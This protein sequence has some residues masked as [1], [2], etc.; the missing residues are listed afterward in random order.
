MNFLL[1]IKTNDST[2]S[3]TETEK[4]ISLFLFHH[5]YFFD[6]VYICF[7]FTNICLFVYRI[8][9]IICLLFDLSILHISHFTN[10]CF[11]LFFNITLR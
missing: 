10:Y 5:K 4:C 3:V 1:C 9:K 2:V 7:Y 11:I 6:I 8:H